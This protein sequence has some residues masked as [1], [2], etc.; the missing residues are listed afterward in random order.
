MRNFNLVR[1]QTWTYFL[2]RV[3]QEKL[4]LQ[5]LRE[6]QDLLEES[7]YQETRDHKE[8]LE[9]RFMVS[10]SYML[11]V[12]ANSLNCVDQKVSRF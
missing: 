1:G 6:V 12:E 2:L 3:H 7:V 5:E 4:E 8:R 10:F 11:S 9:N